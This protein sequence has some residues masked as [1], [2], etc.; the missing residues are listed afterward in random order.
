MRR[1]G[2]EGPP[3]RPLDDAFSRR[4]WRRIVGCRA[5]PRRPSARSVQA[6]GVPSI[7]FSKACARAGCHPEGITTPARGPVRRPAL[8]HLCTR[9]EI[10]LLILSPYDGA[11]PLHPFPRI[12]LTCSRRPA[13]MAPLLG[14]PLP[15]STIALCPFRRLGAPA[16]EASLGTSEFSAASLRPHRRQYMTSAA[17]EASSSSS[18]SPPPEEDAPG[19]G[20]CHGID[21]ESSHHRPLLS[22]VKR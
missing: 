17:A 8:L 13:S 19:G 11:L 22:R 10:F 5:L 6:G 1:L 4:H 9:R 3:P 7:F 14:N 2:C 12:S 20:P 18:S 21:C 16:A 15:L